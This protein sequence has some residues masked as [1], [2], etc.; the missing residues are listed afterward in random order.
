MRSIVFWQWA[1]QTL[2]GESNMALSE[3]P[4][5]EYVNCNKVCV[6]YSNANKVGGLKLSDMSSQGLHLNLLIAFAE[7]IHDAVGDCQ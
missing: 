2:N 6:N 7:Y 5:A 1:N 3:C 4:G